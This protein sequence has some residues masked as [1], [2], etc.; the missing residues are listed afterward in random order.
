MPRR[1]Q[2]GGTT[3]HGHIARALR[4]TSCPSQHEGIN[5]HELKGSQTFCSALAY[6][7][8]LLSTYRPSTILFSFQNFTLSK[9]E[10]VG[11]Q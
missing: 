4:E 2:D 6:P 8:I 11:L 7:W 10:A 5:H 3:D 9:P 1:G